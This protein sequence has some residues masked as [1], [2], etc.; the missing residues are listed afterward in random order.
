MLIGQRRQ[1]KIPEG[2]GP[3][4]KRVL[5]MLA[6]VAGA[7]EPMS[8]AAGGPIAAGPGRGAPLVGLLRLWPM[9]FPVDFG[10]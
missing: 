10:K 6:L 3:F 2:E 4:M 9:L 5:F 8:S 7:G 1:A